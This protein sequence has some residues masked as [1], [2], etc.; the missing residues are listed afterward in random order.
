MDKNR[1]W[2]IGAVALSAL[3]L[4]GGWFVAIA[5]QLGAA[6]QAAVQRAQIDAQNA[7]YNSQLQAL[8]DAHAKLPE[9]QAQLAE[10]AKAIPAD[11]GLPAFYSE[12][13]QL[14]ASAGVTITKV[15]PSDAVPY[16]APVPPA[17]PAAAASASGSSTAT[18]TPAPAATPTPAPSA[19]SVPGMPPVQNPA[20]TADNLSLIPIVITASGSQAQLQAF[21]GAI[22]SGDRLFLVTGSN[23]ASST[24]GPGWDGR[25]SGYLF[26]LKPTTAAP[27]SKH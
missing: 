11:A 17:A 24:T 9:T 12:L 27:A 23:V 18:P 6:G 3:V 22:Q 1:L 16:T 14:A 13:N 5:P 8:K 2:I 20:I 25:V 26:S 10:L 21:V 15:T 7:T 19:S 4:V